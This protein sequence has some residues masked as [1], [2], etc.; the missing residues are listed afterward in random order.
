MDK[1]QALDLLDEK[2]DLINHVSDAVWDAAE[3]AFSETVSAQVI[4]QALKQEDFEIQEN[5]GGIS[6]AFSGSFGSGA[7]I[8]GILGEFD[9][10]S[11]LSQQS[12]VLQKCATAQGGNGHGCGHNNLGAGSL[13]AAIAAKEYI[14]QNNMS[15]TV[16][17][18][19]CPGEEG[20][21][22]KAFMA[23]EGVF[24][25]LDCAISWH[26]GDANIV[27]V[28]SSL[29]NY[30]I[31]YRFYGVSAHAAGAPHL[32][33]SALDAVE[34]LNIG[35]QFLREHVTPEARM[36]YAITNT[37]GFSPNVVQPYAEVLYLL[38]APK[39]P[40]V[41]EIYERVNDIAKGAALM[42]GTRVEIE[43]IKACSNIVPN[44]VLEEKL[45]QSLKSVAL[46]EIT[47]QEYE[48]AKAYYDTVEKK[49][50]TLHHALKVARGE[51]KKQLAEHLNDAYYNF[52]MP[53]KPM[54][55]VMPGSTDVGD[56]SWV[57]PTG[58]IST[59]VWAACTPGHSWQIVAQG[60]NSIAH[61]ATLY[62]AKVMADTII[63]LLNDP[64]AIAQAK[65]ELAERLE[66]GKYICPIPK[67]V[68]P[69]VI[70]PNKN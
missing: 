27:T 66:G 5:L 51:E 29:A 4:M 58:Q 30:Q 49:S 16:V 10:L 52:V 61:K 15:G 54:D 43:F 18:F 37:G 68:K 11:G 33:R 64:Q 20:G 63:E 14:K 2:F 46:P 38:R 3:T 70:D 7:P 67:D 41:A 22:G 1:L 60:K 17:Y 44:N 59:A 62:A 47:A 28:Q 13:G 65:E 25:K 6:T 55:L 53:Y 39:T 40:E 57:A 56:V 32:G 42:T 26:P 45:Y 24:D 21:S 31:M 69:R 19:G 34:L 12:D 9:A 50:G 48:M 35:V 23:R 36:H 8:I